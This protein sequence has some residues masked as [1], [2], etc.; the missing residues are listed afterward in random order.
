MRADGEDIVSIPNDF[1]KL[2]RFVTLVADVMFVNAVPFLVTKSQ[3]IGLR[4]AEHVPNRTGQPR[5]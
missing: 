2:H 4:T 1:Y 3:K 5:C